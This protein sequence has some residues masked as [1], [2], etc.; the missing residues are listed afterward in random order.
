[1]F[2]YTKI[3]TDP[4]PSGW[5]NLPNTSTPIIANALQQFTNTIK[6]IEDFLYSCHIPTKTSELTNDSN[7]AR[8][9]D[10]PTV[11]TKVSDLTN[12][13]DFV[14]RDEIT[15]IMEE[16][17]AEVIDITAIPTNT[18]ELVND[19]GFIDESYLEGKGYATVEYVDELIGNVADILDSINGEVI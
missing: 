10:I 9:T 12:D 11:P 19:S 15:E 3:F 7:F 18:S 2:N 17:V 16:V 8:T 14:P 5:K 4:Y 13:S 6:H 1:M